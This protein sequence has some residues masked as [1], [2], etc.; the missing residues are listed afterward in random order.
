M[1]NEDKV[2]VPGIV[3][4]T[5]HTAWHDRFK[6]DNPETE[7][8]PNKHLSSDIKGRE[9][10]ALHESLAKGKTSCAYSQFS[11]TSTRV[12]FYILVVAS[13][14]VPNPTVYCSNRNTAAQPLVMDVT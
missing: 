8:T 2:I 14:R 5:R 12:N 11:R 13:L 7:F 9:K 1:R 10:T 4:G 6:I 3:Y